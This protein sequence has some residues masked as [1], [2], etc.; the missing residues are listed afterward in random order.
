ML[1]RKS[2]FAVFNAVRLD[3]GIHIDLKPWPDAFH[4]AGWEFSLSFRQ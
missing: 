4:Q 2:G 1:S 3:L